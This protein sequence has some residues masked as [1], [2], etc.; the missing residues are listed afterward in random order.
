MPDPVELML[1]DLEAR[2]A[3]ALPSP[4]FSRLYT[5]ELRFGH[6]FAILHEQLNQ[7]FDAIN[8]RAKS[9]KHYWADPSRVLL[10]LIEEISDTLDTLKVAGHEVDFAAGYKAALERCG[11]WLSSSGGSTVPDDFQ[12][13]RLVK[14]EPVFTIPGLTVPL[15]KQQSG[16]RLK[17]VG[18]GS[19]ATVFSFEDPDYGVR[20]AVKR[21]KKDLPER[22]LHRF[23]QEYDILKN[24][25]F[26][27]IVQVFGYDESRHEYQMEFCEDTLRGFIRSRNNKLLFATRKRIALQFLYGI[28]YIHL[29]GYLHRD[30]SLQN[31]LVKVFDMGAV[32]VKLSDFGL[33]KSPS[34]E[35]THTHTEMKGTI[36]DPSLAN[37][38]D[39]SVV[40]EIHAVGWVLSY[41]FT[42]RE[43][44]K[45]GR[46]ELSW[47]IQKC[48]AHDPAQRYQRVPDLIADV[49]SLS[50]TPMHAS[51]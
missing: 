39:Y 21:A 38:R 14:F 37:F 19:Y 9:T 24:L 3:E 5:D 49:E 36:R 25:R 1:T 12:Q 33:V 43:A 2:Y 23:R 51:A 40:N 41:I 45:S 7:H 47:I 10:S 13:I 6:V 32:E 34:S 46:D 16:A 18:Q 27:Y 29:K 22:E 15:R 11:P 26:P 30:I 35:F 48:A 20:I 4:A 44:L 31:V 50:A 42:G 28:N 17:M 8:D